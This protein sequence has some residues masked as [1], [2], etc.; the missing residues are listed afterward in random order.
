MKK[1]GGVIWDKICF[2]TVVNNVESH[3]AHK[4]SKRKETL[5]EHSERAFQVFQYIA[6]K[7]D[8]DGALNRAFKNFEISKSNKPGIVLSDE[9]VR[10]IKKL[11]ANTIYLHD[12]GKINPMFQLKKMDNDLSKQFDIPH[13]TAMD[14]SNH[15]FLSTAIYLDVF[16][17]ETKK[18]KNSLER[19]F[20]EYVMLSFAF[21]IWTHHENLFNLDDFLKEEFFQKNMI[22]PTEQFSYAYFYTGGLNL[23]SQIANIQKKM[24]SN[25]I[26]FDGATLMIVNKLLHST[27]ISS[28]FI[29]TYQFI[30]DIQ[31][32]EF[33]LGLI[34]NPGEIHDVY[35]NSEIYKGIRSYERDNTYFKDYP[36]N[37]LRSELF[38]EA[39]A[40]LKKVMNDKRIFNLEMPTGSGKTNTSIHLALSILSETK[41]YD[42]LFYVFPFNTLVDQTKQSFSAIFGDKLVFEA[43]NSITPVTS[44]HYDT[45]DIDYERTLLNRQ[46]LGYPATFTSHVNLFRILFGAGRQS[47]MPLFQLCN[48]VIILDEIQ[49]YRNVIWRE[50][51][52]LLYQYAEILNIKVIIMSAT[53]PNLQKLI[54]F[55]KAPFGNLIHNPQAYYQNKL[56][57]E[58]VILKDDLLKKY[59]DF[60]I[61]YQ[62][63][64]EALALRNKM[65]NERASM[66]LVEF[67]KK[68]TANKFYDDIS[69]KIDK[70]THDMYLLTG[71]TN[72][73]ER[74]R[75]LQIIKSNNKRVDKRNIILITTQIIE[76]GVDIDMD[77]GFKDKALL[78]N[79]E[80]FLGRINRSCLKVNCFAYLFHYD[81]EKSIYKDDLRLSEKLSFLEHLDCLRSKD[82]QAFYANNFARIHL[83]NNR[84]SNEGIEYF[85]QDLRLLKWKDIAKHMELINE[86]NTIQV[87]IPYVLEKEVVEKDGER[88][89]D[90]IDGN[91]VWEKFLF[92]IKEYGMSYAE[93]KIRLMN[94]RE[95]IQLFTFQV[96]ASDILDIEP[97]R[98]IY[99]IQGGERYMKG[100]GLNRDLFEAEIKLVS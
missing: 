8:I 9:S 22:L 1:G 3:F 41:G 58:R 48:S 38:L 87:F 28:D 95:Q 49:A 12:I 84:F 23:T 15:S 55:E 97:V 79:D 90:L 21:I 75:I 32:V 85:Y 99:Y 63:I 83:K 62:K 44:K 34:K 26:H 42:K 47:G 51:I 2:Q 39:E 24:V 16:T 17:K 61:L 92:L 56:F 78:D 98:G 11:F 20:V 67:I 45:G 96:Y 6:E 31:E 18:L 14:S 91:N 71:D 66:V 50:I 35:K 60:N 76:A 37:V 89:V 19:W 73:L 46:I 5:L 52:E 68:D 86:D 25:N 13:F 36:I 7:K 77:I 72:V 40:I 4:T 93:K 100:N 74:E 10:L 27:L 54:G 65:E 53:L 43:V 30:N 59:V 29:S 80:Q 82:F 57:R 94:L 81:S 69:S 33:D 88:K 70:E 64:V